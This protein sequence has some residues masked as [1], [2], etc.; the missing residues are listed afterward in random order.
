MMKLCVKKNNFGK[1]DIDLLFIWDMDK[2]IINP[3]LQVDNSD[4]E[5]K[6]QRIDREGVDLF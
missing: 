5:K 4:G 2:G 3:Y 6:T 1:A